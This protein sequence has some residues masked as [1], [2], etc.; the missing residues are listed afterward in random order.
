MMRDA[1]KGIDDDL[2]ISS[3]YGQ[4]NAMVY[5]KKEGYKGRR[6]RKKGHQ[7]SSYVASDPGKGCCCL[8]NYGTIHMHHQ[9]T[10]HVT[11]PSTLYTLNL[12]HRHRP[13]HP[14]PT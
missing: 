4:C 5:M 2:V 7:G 14:N 1:G 9:Q 11:H 8:F 12:N 13:N 10:Y 6:N 3:R